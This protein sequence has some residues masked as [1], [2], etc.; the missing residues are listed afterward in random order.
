MKRVIAVLFTAI[1][2]CSLVFAQEAEEKNNV[3]APE[4][5]FSVF[6]PEFG[7]LIGHNNAEFIFSCAL[8]GG[9]VES[10][11]LFFDYVEG[12]AGLLT[13]T[14]KIHVGYNFN[15]YDTGWQDSVG[16][17][18]ASAVGFYE[19]GVV[20]NMEALGFYYRGGVKIKQGFEVGIT[21]YLP[22]VYFI[23][24]PDDFKITTIGGSLGFWECIGA[25]FLCS[26]LNFRWYF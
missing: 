16:L 13:V 8:T 7:V 24:S 4:L 17:A 23:A 26:S 1:L 9:N 25:G 21:S 11:S 2:A 6:G 19:N 12:S 18:Y 15:G 3:V 5:C 10:G 20:Q 22:F 14:P